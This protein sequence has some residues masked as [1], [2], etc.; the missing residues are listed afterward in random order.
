ME[1]SKQLKEVYRKI[2]EKYGCDFLAASDVAEPSEDDREHLNPE[3]HKRLAE[4]IL[5]SVAR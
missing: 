4:A 2:A 3:G 5:Q 1:V